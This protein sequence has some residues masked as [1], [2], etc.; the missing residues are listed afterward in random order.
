MTSLEFISI[1]LTSV[2]SSLGITAFLSW[3]LKSWIQERLTQSIKY[4][5]DSQLEEL[6]AG[7]VEERTQRL[8]RSEQQFNM[9]ASS[10]M[11][12]QIFDH[13]VEFSK[14]YMSI[15]IEAFN[16]IRKASDYSLA[17]HHSQKLLEIRA[18]YSLWLT[19]EIDEDLSLFEYYLRMIGVN[20]QLI[21]VPEGEFSDESFK[22]ER[23]QELMALLAA[24]INPSENTEFPEMKMSHIV[25]CLR[26]II[27]V[28]ELVKLRNQAIAL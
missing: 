7:L 23:V 24:F 3:F 12:I 9:A 22:R 1:T 21:K 11:A 19:M 2:F 27:G 20:H 17:I 28:K 26:K 6:K 25:E 5:Y 16:E 18:K 14:Q 4:G 8:H 10:H 15:V 13:Q